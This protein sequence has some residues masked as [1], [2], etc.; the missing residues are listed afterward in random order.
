[1][2][3]YHFQKALVVLGGDVLARGGEHHEQHGGGQRA[4]AGAAQAE[5]AAQKVLAE[6]V[7]PGLRG[8]GGGVAQ[9]AG[10]AQ[11]NDGVLA[12]GLVG[13]LAAVDGLERQLDPELEQLRVQA[14]AGAD[15]VDFFSASLGGGAGVDGDEQGL[16]GDGLV[17]DAVNAADELRKALGA[18]AHVLQGLGNGDAHHANAQQLAKVLAAEVLGQGPGDQVAALLGGAL[19]DGLLG[20]QLADAALDGDVEHAEEAALEL[21]GGAGLVGRQAGGHEDEQLVGRGVAE[22]QEVVGGVAIVRGGENGDDGVEEGLRLGVV[23]EEDVA[24]DQVELALAGGRESGPVLGVVDRCPEAEQSVQPGFDGVVLAV[25][26]GLLQRDLG[27]RLGGGVAQALDQ[28]QTERAAGSLV[29]S[30][31]GGDYH[32]AL[33]AERLHDGQGDGRGLL[34][35][36][37]VKEVVAGARLG[38]DG[39]GLHKLDAGAALDGE[40][41]ALDVAVPA[42]D[43]HLRVLGGAEQ[44]QATL[45][46]A[47]EGL[48]VLHGGGDDQNVAEAHVQCGREKQADGGAFAAATGADD[49]RDVEAL[50][51]FGA[52]GD[53]VEQGDEGLQ[54]AVLDA[55]GGELRQQLQLEGVVL[56]SGEREL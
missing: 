1:M 31:S 39:A 43:D 44:L 51:D 7:D 40:G 11:K 20:H 55:Q 30:D 26:D 3:A 14:E 52:L 10:R 35:N 56:A 42:R 37:N 4:P 53:R 9:L 34:D 29:A 50:H 19:G 46:E 5:E 54:L 48:D 15:V 12:G 16:P 45:Q 27:Q 28:L 25:P 38:V 47:V 8:R 36:Q 24:V 13:D 22:E 21:G 6:L 32:Y 17:D 23:G 18:V 41:Q 33:F 2:S 49:G